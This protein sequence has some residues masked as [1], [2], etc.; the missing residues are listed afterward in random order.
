MKALWLDHDLKYDGAQLRSLF[1]YLEHGVQGDSVIAWQGAC[2]VALDHM[3]DGED[4]R[5]GASIRG[6][7]MVHFIIEKFN[8]TL[9]AAVALQRLL[10]S[11]VKDVIQ[12]IS[13]NLEI[14]EGL[15]RQGDDLFFGDQKFSISIATVS[16]VSALIHFAVNV[17]ND[18]TPVSTLCLKDLGVDPVVFAKKILDRF[19]SESLDILNATQKVQWVR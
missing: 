17:V 9:F 2:D 15:Y 4:R 6:D 3:V 10:A 7:K 13:P 8:C 16:P 19:S 1:A 18:G 12:E 5:A 11:I 14:A